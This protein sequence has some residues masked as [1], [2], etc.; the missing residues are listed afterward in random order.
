MD[1]LGMGRQLPVCSAVDG[2]GGARRTLICGD[3]SHWNPSMY[4]RAGNETT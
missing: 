2:I 1:L 3:A 4:V